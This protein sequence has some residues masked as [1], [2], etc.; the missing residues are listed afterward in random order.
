MAIRHVI[1][2]EDMK[3]NLFSR[4]ILTKDFPQYGLKHGD[5]GVVVE[6]IARPTEE[7]GYIVEFFDAQGQ[8][9]DV[10][11]FLESDLEQPRSNTILTYR[12]LDRVA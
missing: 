9:V 2:S 6:H 12:E 4:A 3:F 11:P 10:V 8:T 1:S 7:D 5:M